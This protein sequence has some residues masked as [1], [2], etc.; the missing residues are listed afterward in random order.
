MG[1]WG[2]LEKLLDQVQEHSPAVGKIWLMVLFVFRI[3]ILGL[4]GESVWG[5]E[6][7]DFTCNTRQPGC[8]NVC[9]DKA[10]PISH[11]RYWV[12]QFLF[13]STPTLVY[14]A[15]VVY[16]SR[17]EEK[18][19]QRESELRVL[20]EDNIQVGQAIADI[21][22]KLSKITVYEDGRVKIQGALMVTY[23]TSVLFKIIFE[24]GFLLGQW[25]LYGFVMHAV[26]VCE[27]VPC[28]Q[29]VDCFVSRPTEKTIFIIFM[30]VVSLVSLVL[31]VLEL[32]HL[33]GK[34]AVRSMKKQSAG[35]CT[36]SPREE[37]HGMEN[38]PAVPT[39]PFPDKTFFFLP[40]GGSQPP[41]PVDHGKHSY[42]TSM[43]KPSYSLKA[44]D[45]PYSTTNDRN[46]CPPSGE[47]PQYPLGEDYAL[48]PE[49]KKH[50]V[51]PT[52]G[53]H[54][55]YVRHNTISRAQNRVN[56]DVEQLQVSLGGQKAEADLFPLNVSS[57]AANAEPS[58]GAHRKPPSR[59]SSSASKQQYV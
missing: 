20:Q 8:V 13:I 3:L 47:P 40:I 9:Y 11:I 22:K 45:P 55:S 58:S 16:L 34:R 56:R 39:A 12:L 17:R 48:W 29:I 44:I 52:S 2:F 7:S 26:Y 4:A 19:K 30:M 50:S 54:P 51:H 1:D 46:A 49:S 23:T 18:L 36:A 57:S 24:A 10:F 28:P 25:Y 21:E 31:S 37:D 35:L 41:Y 42:P 59:T 6:Q 32:M 53:E 14:L 43:D 38:W 33:A 27:R 15:H 5:D